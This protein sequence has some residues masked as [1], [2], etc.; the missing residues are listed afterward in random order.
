MNDNNTKDMLLKQLKQTKLK[1]LIVFI[2]IALASLIIGLAFG[3]DENIGGTLGVLFIADLVIGPIVYFSYSKNRK[4]QIMR[5]FCPYCSAKFD[6]DEDISWKE[7]SKTSS[8]SKITSNVLF[9]CD[10]PECEKTTKFYQNINTAI[11]DSKTSSWSY[12]DIDL[13]TNNIFIK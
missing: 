11:F 3:D 12:Y 10:C 9:E 13:L 4:K 8:P 7:V 2:M 6:Y 1:I 5:S